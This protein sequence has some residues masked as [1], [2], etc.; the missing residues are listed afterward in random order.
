MTGHRNFG[1]ALVGLTLV[2]DAGGTAVYW[3]IDGN[4]GDLPMV[5]LLWV[6]TL[7][8]GVA[9]ALVLRRHPGHRIGMLL[10][11]QGPLVGVVLWADAYPELADA[12]GHL[13]DWPFI[14]SFAEWSE[15]SW[16]LLFL[17]MASI[18]YLFPTG[19]PV[20]PFWRRW[21]LLCL[22]GFP[23]IVVGGWFT[24]TEF[25]APFQD[26]DHP[27]PA[28]PGLGSV[29][30]RLA[31]PLLLG[32]LIG[33]ALAARA[34]L[35]RAEGVDRLQLL[36]FAWV[37]LLVPV[38]LLVC[39]LDN[40]LNGTETALTLGAIALAGTLVP[41]AIGVAVLRYRLFDIELVVSKTLLYT[42]LVAVV[43]IVYVAVVFGLGSIISNRGAAGFVAVL[44]VA[45]LVEPLRARLHRSAQRWVYGDRSDPYLALSRLG[46]RL[47]ETLAPLDVLS[48]VCDTLIEAL[49]LH[50]AAIALSGPDGLRV[51]THAGSSTGR[52]LR[53][54]PLVHQGSLMGEL[55]VEGGQL[56]PADERLLHE[57]AR[58]AGVA[59]HAVRLSLDLQ[60]SRSRLVTAQEEERRRLRRDL[61]D[62]LGPELASIVMRLD[63]A[64]LMSSG[65]LT[66][67][68][69]DLLGQTRGAITEIRRLVEGLRP[70][71]LD[72]VGLAGALRQQAVRLS[73]GPV[74]ISVSDR[75]FSGPLPAAVEVA[76][77]RIAVEAMT[78]AVRHSQAASCH[79]DLVLN[80]HLEVD[81]L[82]DGIGVG[83]PR[84]DGVGLASMQERATELG[85]TCEVRRRPEGGTQV[86]A[87]LP[88]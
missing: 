32:Y 47:Q 18:G 12:R 61:H 63:G 48:T 45:V 39:F 20:S 24:A 76:A 34:R 13:G 8:S 41:V 67:V 50:Y 4:V 87:E 65:D 68:L 51:V 85:G 58:Q 72:E 74:S 23:L 46:D 35:K 78:N 22:A 56:S 3:Q 10:A 60:H 62:G 27:L 66:P 17:S 16:P 15:N 36:W 25:K 2:L 30:G 71:S 43:S 54:I 1:W 84:G 11:A 14:G 70:P 7:A 37:A 83:A 40:A 9:G 38:S 5:A 33:A 73:E 42:G 75:G 44:V 86:H 79:V 53:A 82:D 52:E 57:L 55:T 59:V 88:T 31:L 49:R 21:Q 64:R 26:I 29:L 28:I 19:R 6:F 77:Y 80:G 69:T 81:V